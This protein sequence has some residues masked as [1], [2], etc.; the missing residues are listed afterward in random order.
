MVVRCNEGVLM[1]T[2]PA[3]DEADI[4]RRIDRLANAI[5]ARDLEGVLSM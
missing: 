5:R 2:Q 4:R 3:I 1:A